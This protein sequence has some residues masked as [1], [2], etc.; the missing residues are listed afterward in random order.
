MDS[1]QLERD[2]Q[3]DPYNLEVE[4]V[5]QTDL[6]CGY[7]QEA[8]TARA[9]MDNADKAVDDAKE[10]VK[11]TAARLSL[12]CRENP[13]AFNLPKATEASIEAAVRVHPD[14]QKALAA[15]SATSQDYVDARQAYGELEVAVKAMEMKKSM[16]EALVKLHGQ[17]YFAGPSVPRSL[18]DAVNEFQ[19][20]RQ[21]ALAQPPKRVVR[22]REG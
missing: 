14:F 15:Q 12:V 5:R 13:L 17:Q 4:C 2:R 7:A 1:A 11:N 18:A 16:L 20:N 8:I 10:I 9:A 19:T 22:R 21:A 3:I 6:F